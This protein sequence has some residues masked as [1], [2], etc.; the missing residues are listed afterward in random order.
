MIKRGF[1]T[2]AASEIKENIDLVEKYQEQF[3][4]YDL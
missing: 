4:L 1:P 3:K 2:L